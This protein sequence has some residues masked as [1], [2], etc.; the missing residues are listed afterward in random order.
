MRKKHTFFVSKDD[1]NCIFTS[2]K[3]F[4]I[5]IF[6]KKRLVFRDIKPENILCV[7]KDDYTVVK[8]RPFFHTKLKDNFQLTDFGLAK[9]RSVKRTMKTHCGTPTYIAPEMIDNDNTP[10]TD[11]VDM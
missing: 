3:I 9:S 1:I 6:S 7:G 5:L 11:K 2:F 10:Y 8:V 4:E